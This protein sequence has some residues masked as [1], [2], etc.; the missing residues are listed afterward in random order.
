[1]LFE[2]ILITIQEKKEKKLWFLYYYNFYNS[3]NYKINF[4]NTECKIG[5]NNYVKK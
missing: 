4:I 5:F 1:M 2:G 3:N